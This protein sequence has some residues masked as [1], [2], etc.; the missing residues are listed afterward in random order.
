MKTVESKI[1][2]YSSLTTINIQQAMGFI[3]GRLA[4]R[5]DVLVGQEGKSHVLR[6]LF[7]TDKSTGRQ[8]R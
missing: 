3:L 2:A 5:R 1:S 7:Y 8:G 6:V 4:G